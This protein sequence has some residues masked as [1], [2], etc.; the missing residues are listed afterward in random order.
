MCVFLVRIDLR[1]A[2]AKHGGDGEARAM[3]ALDLVT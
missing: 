2:N 3:K 1:T